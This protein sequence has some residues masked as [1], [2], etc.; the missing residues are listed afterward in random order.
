MRAFNVNVHTAVPGQGTQWT[1]FTMHG[2]SK[3]GVIEAL[4]SLG[5]PIGTFDVTLIVTVAVALERIQYW[6]DVTRRA[7]QIAEA[8]R[9]AQRTAAE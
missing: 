3:Q 5:F 7:V 1:C 2:E 8:D 9:V 4:I 6:Q